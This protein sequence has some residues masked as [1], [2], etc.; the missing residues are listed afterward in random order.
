MDRE[1][2]IDREKFIMPNEDEKDIDCNRQYP[3]KKII[4]TKVIVGKGEEDFFLE[5][6]FNFD[7]I[8]DAEPFLKI[9]DID[10][11]VD[12]YDA[13]VIKGNKVIFNAWIYK[14]VTYKMV[15]GCLEESPDG[16]VTINGAIRHITK[17]IPLAGCIDIK[18]KEKINPKE[19]IA[20][21][22]DAYV[23]GEVEETLEKSALRTATAKVEPPIYEYKKLHE[24]MCVKIAVKVVRWEHVQIKTE[25]R[26]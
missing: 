26:C 16:E 7:K 20:E 13:Q 21:V 24:K 25:E 14:N 22:L 10:T 19:D 8:P 11:W 9:V 4:Q 6:D 17:R 3:D 2:S 15:K 1:K 12:V 18:S 23:I 5:S